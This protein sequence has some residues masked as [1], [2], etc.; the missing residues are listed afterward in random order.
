MLLAAIVAA[1]AAGVATASAPAD[2]PAAGDHGAAAAGCAVTPTQVVDV[3]RTPYGPTPGWLAGDGLWLGLGVDRA[4]VLGTP[5]GRGDGSDAYPGQVT[6]NGS[7][8]VK[9]LWRRA[10]KGSGRLWVMGHSQP[11]S[12]RF[13]IDTGNSYPQRKFVPSGITFP[14]PGCWSVAAKAG[15]AKLR[16]VVWVATAP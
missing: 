3:P 14:G 12:T 10:K 11:G 8:R 1:L 5:D 6:R 16:F 9:F 4:I 13:R 15:S 7:V 2:D